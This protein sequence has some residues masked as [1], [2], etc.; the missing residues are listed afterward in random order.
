MII[1]FLY[2]WMKSHYWS[3]EIFFLHKVTLW[4]KA[5]SNGHI[6]TWKVYRRKW[7]KEGRSWHQSIQYKKTMRDQMNELHRTVDLFDHL[8]PET[9]MI[10]STCGSSVDLVWRIIQSIDY[11]FTHQVPNSWDSHRILDR[12]CYAFCS[13]DAQCKWSKNSCNRNKMEN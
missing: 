11:Y 12:Q 3:L 9:T 13:H 4:K 5:I 6:L 1:L 10:E 8:R 2:F 7:K